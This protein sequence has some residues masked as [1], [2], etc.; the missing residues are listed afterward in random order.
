MNNSTSESRLTDEEIG[1]I[2]WDVSHVLYLKAKATAFE[3]CEKLG[4]QMTE[5]RRGGRAGFSCDFDAAVNEGTRVF[6]NLLKE[7]TETDIAIVLAS[8]HECSKYYGHIKSRLHDEYVKLFDAL[9]GGLIYIGEGVVLNN[10]IIH[11][12]R[13]DYYALPGTIGEAAPT[14]EQLD[15]IRLEVDEEL[16]PFRNQVEAF[17]STISNIEPRPKITHRVS[18]LL[19]LKPTTGVTIMGDVYK[20]IRDS[21]IISR[22]VVEVWSYVG[23]SI[24]LDKLAS[25]LS[26][27]RATMRNEASTAEHDMAIGEIA[28]AETA[29]KEG[30]GARALQHLKSAGKWAWDVATKLGTTVA[31]EAISKA[32]G[33]GTA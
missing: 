22:S 15:Q 31:A 16:R 14:P 19:L 26:Q 32:L 10:N 2:P 25:E 12:D 13:L 33:L 18:E 27:L 21:T 29:A 23:A 3:E 4:L 28:T 7:K 8:G 11:M 24:N 17:Y 1:D 6:L 20:N 5:P 30:D 9:R